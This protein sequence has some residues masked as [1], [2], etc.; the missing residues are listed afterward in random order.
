MRANSFGRAVA[1]CLS[2]SIMLTGCA[3]GV[4]GLDSKAEYDCKA[5]KGVPCMSMS[6]AYANAR[7]GLQA[8]PAAGT[9]VAAAAPTSAAPQAAA[10]TRST[11]D[12]SPPPTLPTAPAAQPGAVPRVSPAAMSAPTS[13]LPLRTPERILRIWVAAVEDAEGTLHDQR[14]LYVTVERGQWQL[15]TFQDAARAPF[16]PVTR[17]AGASAEPP[18]PNRPTPSQMADEA[19]RAGAAGLRGPGSPVPPATAEP[20]RIQ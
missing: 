15:E 13:G 17:Q 12:Y 9:A 7:G 14:Y 5:P 16:R 3:G 1:S 11:I 18:P 19:A 4:T 20:G 6:G 10:A 2:V 8:P